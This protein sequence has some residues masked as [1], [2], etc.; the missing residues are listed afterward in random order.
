MHRVILR[1][2]RDDS[3]KRRHPWIFSGA[4]A[5]L[6]GTPEVGES[7]LVCT[8]AGRAC[9]VG[10]WSPQSQIRVRLWSFDPAAE[11]DAAFL[12]GR[13]R[14]AVAFR[15][16]LPGLSDSS[17]C[18]LVAAEVDGLPGLI[19]DRYGDF[20]VVQFLSAGVERWKPAIVAALVAAAPTCRGIY[21]RSDTD[22]RAK[23]GL[24]AACGTLAGDEPP[25]LIEVCEPVGRFLVDVRGGHKTGWY[26]DQR[27]N[28]A[29]LQR[30]VDGGDVLN[31]FCYSGGFTIAAA[32]A[33]AASVTSVDASAPA[34]RLLEKNAAL[35][36]LDSGRLE[37]LEADVFKLLRLFRDQ[38]R[39]FD[40]IVLDPPKFAD[41]KAMLDRAARGYKDI[42]LLGFKLLRPGGTL[43]TF[44]CSGQMTA[45]LFQKIVA[46]AA[47]DAGR[48]AVVLETLGQSPDHPVHLAIP[49]SHYLKGLVCRTRD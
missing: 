3:L 31:C 1:P 38:G 20:L 29:R 9:G 12:A 13:L 41:S 49:E 37:N 35:N 6:E 19:V 33:G 42:N 45:P 14:Q 2:D 7:V 18:R 5:H 8:H 36:R 46:D 34:L 27:E 47:L 17:A 28:R 48:D 26:L 32:Q 44:S 11:V 24:A 40:C 30:H 21:E 39:S 22:A 25:E 23:E 15:G 16:R 4:I 10:A 43:V